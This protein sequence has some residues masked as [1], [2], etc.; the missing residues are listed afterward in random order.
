MKVATGCKAVRAVAPLFPRQ[1]KAQVVGRVVGQ[2]VVVLAA[3][4]LGSAIGEVEPRFVV[5]IRETES[6]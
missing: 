3:E 1:G 4:V 2:H 5:L 6:G